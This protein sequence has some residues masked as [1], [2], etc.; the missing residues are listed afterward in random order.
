MGFV[1]MKF[2]SGV[3]LDKLDVHTDLSIATRTINA[4]QHLA[5]IPMGSHQGPGPVECGA[6]HD[7]LW[8]EDGTGCTLETVDSME[9]WLNKRL[10]VVNEP[11]ISLANQELEMRHMDFARRNICI[12]A[13]QRTC[14]LGWGFA[15]FYPAI[16][17]IQTFRSL[18]DTDSDWFEQL[19]RLSPAPN[20][21]EEEIMQRLEL[22]AAINDRYRLVIMED[23][24]R[25]LHN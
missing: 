4:I 16:F 17:E 25:H 10:A 12:L 22:P 2:V 8:P 18:L 13:D 6:A 7:Y 14:F 3:G 20:S 11:L 23:K 9:G 15:G 19:L 21:N 24:W 5:T 1:V